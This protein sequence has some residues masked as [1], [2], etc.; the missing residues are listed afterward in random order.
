MKI[1][2]IKDCKKAAQLIGVE[3]IDALTI[4]EAHGLS[5]NEEKTKREGLKRKLKTAK[6]QDERLE[7]LNETPKGSELEIE[8]LIRLY[9]NART[10]EER[11]A[12]LLEASAGSVI[13]FKI[14]RDIITHSTSKEELL[15]IYSENSLNELGEES[16]RK[17]CKI[18]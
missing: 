2:T 5:D 17:L 12:V 1:Q 8:A 9:Q 18:L 13:R 7:V 6:S 3:V 10:Q 11:W 4:A 15:K 16:I 14:V